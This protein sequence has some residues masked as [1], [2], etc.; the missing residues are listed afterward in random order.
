M[1]PFD[2]SFRE[3][4]QAAEAAAWFA[5]I[6]FVIGI[7]LAIGIAIWM[8]KG[9]E[10]RGRNGIAAA[11]L[12]LLSAPYGVLPVLIVLC[13][14]I[15]FRPDRRHPSDTK[16]NSSPPKTLP[17]DLVAAPKPEEFLQDLEEQP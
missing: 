17:G 12:P 11:A 15:V 1:P 5:M 16:A 13:A 4:Q 14:W 9:A 6:L 8:F 3:A 7:V 2:Q 10:S